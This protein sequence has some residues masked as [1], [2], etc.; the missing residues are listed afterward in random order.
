MPG[1]GPMLERMLSDGIEVHSCDLF[2][3]VP[4]ENKDKEYFLFSI[5]QL[6]KGVS[7]ILDI[8]NRGKIDLVYTN[9][10][11]VAEG[12]IAAAIA[13]I[14]HVWHV[15][16]MLRF[17]GSALRSPLG[18]D[19]VYSIINDLSERVV[20]VS[21]AV[22]RDFGKCI[23]PFKLRIVYNGSPVPENLVP[24]Q[25]PGSSDLPKIGFIGTI[26]E[27]KGA[28]LFVEA[29]LELLQRGLRANFYLAGS[30]SEN[31]FM[32]SLQE[33][34]RTEHSPFFHFLGHRDDVLQVLKSLD[35]FVL[36][37]RNDPSPRTV[38]EALRLGCPTIVTDSGGA[39]DMLRMAGGEQVVEISAH[40]IADAVAN[41]IRDPAARQ[42]CA[43][44]LQSA[45][46]R[47]FSEQAYAANVER[48]ID[49]TEH[50][51]VLPLTREVLVNYFVKPRPAFRAGMFDRTRKWLWNNSKK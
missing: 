33:R 40:A 51:K 27:R 44:A 23:K 21:H 17:D 29:G 25:L 48:I 41:W 45:S 19:N 47:L 7:R 16:E 50:S 35:I 3:W 1:K 20:A 49:E 4:P 39:R 24:A 9:T 38:V 14:P 22:A 13:R 5:L 32:G 11:V 8:I 12:A 34:I 15:R 6:R 26:N 36:S 28:D 31:G 2:W 10:S 43:T 18:V 37:S 30:C 46:E 42:Q